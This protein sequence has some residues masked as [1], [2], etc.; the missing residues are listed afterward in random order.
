MS[1]SKRTSTSS[2]EFENDSK[3]ARSSSDPELPQLLALPVRPHS[4][5][6]LSVPTLPD[7][8]LDQKI[9]KCMTVALGLNLPK[10]EDLKWVVRDAILALE[11]EHITPVVSKNG[12]DVRFKHGGEQGETKS[13]HPVVESYRKLVANLQSEKVNREGKEGDQ[14]YK[15]QKVVFDAVKGCMDVRKCCNPALIEAVMEAL[16]INPKDEPFL[17]RRIKNAIEDVYFA[18]KKNGFEGLTPETSINVQNLI[19]HLE[20]DRI[21]FLKNIAPSGLLYCVECESGCLADVACASCHDVFCNACM[22]ETHSTGHRL[23]HPAVFLEQCVCSECEC[24]AAIIRC[25][26]CVDLFCY[27]CFKVTHERGKRV[28]HCVT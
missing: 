10:D 24:R 28:K 17:I 8:K 2:R 26:D 27:A 12:Q 7:P 21:K 23:D 1:G 16:A 15:V 22:L 11:Q 5:Y 20:L 19:V 18:Q 14:F 9:V 25:A 4:S 6:K 13:F 3:H